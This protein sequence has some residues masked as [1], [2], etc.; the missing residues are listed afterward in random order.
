MIRWLS[1]GVAAVVVVVLLLLAPSAYVELACRADPVASEYEPILPP[2]HRRAEARTLLTYPEWHIIYA[3]D[4]YAAVIAAGDPHEF[5][6]L[7]AVAGFWTSFCALSREADRLGTESGGSRQTVPVIG[8]SF[9]A[10]MLLKALYEETAGRAA[11]WLR[12]PE[13][14]P[15]DD[16]SAARAADYAAFLRQTPWYRWDFAADAAALVPGRG[17]RDRERAVALGLEARGKALYAR[18]IASAAAAAGPDETRLR[19]VVAGL[20]P[21]A[22]AAMDGATVVAERSEG[23]EVETPRY[24]ALTRLLADAAAAGAEIVEI[25][26]NDDIMVATLGDPVPGALATLARQGQAGR[27]NLR[28]AKVRDLADLLRGLDAEGQQLDHVFDY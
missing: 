28:V 16:L 10:E 3:Y 5:D 6:F 14:A 12:G 17:L 24:G 4:D 7:R 2:E 19:M 11:T 8:V 13:R 27:R 22:L 15:L 26:G 18:A 25:A 23:V 21:E 1:R 20:P 9:T